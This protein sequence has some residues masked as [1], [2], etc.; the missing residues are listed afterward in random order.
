MI[1]SAGETIVTFLTVAQIAFFVGIVVGIALVK[2][3]QR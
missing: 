1:M 3:L 2:L